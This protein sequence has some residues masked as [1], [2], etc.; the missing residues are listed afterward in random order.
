MSGAVVLEA[1]TIYAIATSLT[2][3]GFRFLP[4]S[5]DVEFLET[6]PPEPR[7]IVLPRLELVQP[8]IP[9]AIQPEIQIQTPRP[10]PR[11][12]VARMPRHPVMMPPVQIAR[13]SPPA[14]PAPQSSRGITAPVSI[15][16]SHNC[17]RA[18]PA[19]ALRLDQ[20]GTTIVRFTVNTDGSVSDV[21]V[22]KSSG[23]EMLDDAAIRCAWSWR[24]RPAL[25]N[26]EPVP[27]RWTTNVRWKLQIGSSSM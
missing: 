13:A 27:A 14:P 7:P 25:E 2:I 4:Q 18:Y 15:G 12:T 24:Y 26:G 11:I 9:D 6:N 10:P 20:Q 22:V 21:H 5:M 1:A 19:T 8:P 16:A 3:S 23:H 17:E